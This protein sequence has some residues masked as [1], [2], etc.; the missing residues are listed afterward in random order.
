MT[1]AEMTAFL[2]DL[3]TRLE[4]PARALFDIA[5]RNVMAAVI[6][7][8]AGSLFFLAIA[9]IAFL[10]CLRKVRDF[11]SEAPWDLAVVVTGGAM[12]LAILVCFAAFITGVPRLLTP[13]WYA[14]RDLAGLLP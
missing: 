12:I 6:T 9:V 5:M 14:L 2:E 3:A 4:G 1:A 10:I 7:W 13:E 11:G 8:I